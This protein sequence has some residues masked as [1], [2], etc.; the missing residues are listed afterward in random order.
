MS[1]TYPQGAVVMTEVEGGSRWVI[2]AGQANDVWATTELES[3]LQS[4]GWSTALVTTAQGC[5]EVGPLPAVAAQLQAEADQPIPVYFSGV[6]VGALAALRAA[7]PFET[8]A[9]GL[10]NTF[11]R[12]VGWR[13]RPAPR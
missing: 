6:G 5:S 12:R 1:E 8:G 2:V 7:A 13:E 11:G 3:H 4:A 9:L 10:F